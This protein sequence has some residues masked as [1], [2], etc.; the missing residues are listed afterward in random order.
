MT[1][2]FQALSHDKPARRR[3]RR[4]GHPRRN[5]RNDRS[6]QSARHHSR[7]LDA[8]SGINPP[9]EQEAWRTIIMPDRNGDLTRA[10][11]AAIMQARRAMATVLESLVPPDQVLPLAIVTVTGAFADIVSASTGATDLVALV[12]QQLAGAGLELRPL[13]RN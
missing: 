7:R 8:A 6:Q 1:P 5:N 13:P 4:V 12:N 10:Q 11:H 2:S 3:K 9:G